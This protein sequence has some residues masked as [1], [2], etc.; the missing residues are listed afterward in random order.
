MGAIVMSPSDH[1]GPQAVVG[2]SVLGFLPL[3]F[4]TLL[5]A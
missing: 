1:T 5:L 4:I 2:S 3:P